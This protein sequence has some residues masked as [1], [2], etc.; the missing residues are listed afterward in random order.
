MGG[1]LSKVS[2]VSLT[3][4]AKEGISLWL[5]GRTR[6]CLINSNLS[7]NNSNKVKIKLDSDMEMMLQFVMN[8]PQQ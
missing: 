8:M 4:S 1:H 3:S 2:V 7:F 6:T 5:V